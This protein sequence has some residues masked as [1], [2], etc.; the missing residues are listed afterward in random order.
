MNRVALEDYEVMA[1]DAAAVR[2]WIAGVLTGVAVF[3][4]PLL[5]EIGQ[6]QWQ[7]VLA[8]VPGV[9]MIAIIGGVI[10]LPSAV[11]FWLLLRLAGRVSLPLRRLPFWLAAG[12][13][14]AFPTAILVWNQIYDLNRDSDGAGLATYSWDNLQFP[15]LVMACG[16][17]GAFVAWRSFRAGLT[18]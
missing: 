12:L 15:L 9:A 8:S 10:S 5:W 11:L 4:S 17:V 1:L 3:L 6:I 13:L 7:L 18:E 16:L 2:G 14:G